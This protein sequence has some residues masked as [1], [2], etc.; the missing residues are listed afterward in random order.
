MR[1]MM[2][3]LGGF[4]LLGLSVLAGRLIGGAGTQ[5]MV[6]AA[7]LFIVIWLVAALLNMWMG[8]TSAGYSVAEE[9]PIFL[10]IFALPAAGALLIW[11][12]IS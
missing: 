5:P 3:I 9:L 6:T 8:V 4:V 7:K 2:I 1:T 10:L 11:W 12:K